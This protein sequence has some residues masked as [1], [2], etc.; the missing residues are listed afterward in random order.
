MSS[1]T[2]AN[3][4]AAATSAR[5]A[6][7][8][9]DTKRGRNSRGL[10]DEHVDRRADAERDDLVAAALGADDVERLGADRAGRAGDGDADG[11]YL[12]QG[13]STNVT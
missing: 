9:T 6:G 13:S 12:V 3:G 4:I 5:R 1:T 8:P 7:S 11:A 10:L 2:V